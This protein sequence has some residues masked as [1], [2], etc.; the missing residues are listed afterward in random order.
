MTIAAGTLQLQSS[1]LMLKILTTYLRGRVPFDPYTINVHIGLLQ[2]ALTVSTT[3][4]ELNIKEML[5]ISINANGLL[6]RPVIPYFL[7]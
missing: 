1:Y 2:M 7:P 4:H 6:L 3:K 5:I